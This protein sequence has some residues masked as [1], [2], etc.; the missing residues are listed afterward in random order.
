MKTIEIQ[1]YKFQELSEDAKR[2]A[3]QKCRENENY[4]SYEWY[5]YFIYG[6]ATLAMLGFIYVQF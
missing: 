6:F 1:L 3:I 2:T 4:L 5:D